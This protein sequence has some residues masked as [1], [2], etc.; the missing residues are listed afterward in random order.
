V[1]ALVF[2][3]PGEMPVEDRA[4]PRPGSGEVVVAVRASGICGSDVHGYGGATGRRRIGVVM[5]HEAAGDV[6]EVG[7]GVT[8]ARPGDRVILRSILSCG[9]CDRCRHGQPNICLERQGMG[10]HFDGAYAERI[11]VPETLLVPLPNSLSYEQGAIVEPLAVAM[12]A[13]NITPLDPVDTVVIVGAGAIGLLTLM[14]ARHSGAGTII[15]TDQDPHRLEVARRLGADHAIDVGRSDPVAAIA[16]ATDG[17]GADVVFEAVGID[18]TVAQSVAV[19]RPGGQV[20]WIGN[21]ASVV[22]LSMQQLVTR[23]L[24]VRGAYGFV[25]EFEQAAE[26]LAAGTID[27]ARLIER[28]APLDEG[29]DLFRELAAGRLSAVKVLLCPNPT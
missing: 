9:R 15:V 29:P 2:R 7:P 14:V 28:V 26:A 18:A 16:A 24:T 25:D 10:M 21:S 6:L 22:E 19:A 17:R 8:S 5:G 11:L 3:G 20:T 13:V 23:E 1:K 27:G 4:D 12:H